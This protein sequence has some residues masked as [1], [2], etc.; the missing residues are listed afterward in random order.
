MV[1]SFQLNRN[2]ER[3]KPRFFPIFANFADDAK[4]TTVLREGDLTYRCGVADSIS[5]DAWT[6]RAV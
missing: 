5:V 2:V 3:L 1:I 4:G 6:S